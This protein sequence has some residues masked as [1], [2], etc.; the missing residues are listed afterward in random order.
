MVLVIA[1]DGP[2]LP[3]WR[4][5]IRTQGLEG[6]VILLGRWPHAEL[7]SWFQVADAFVLASNYEG[8][9]HVAIE[10]AMQGLPCVLSDAGGNPE[11]TTL[12]PGFTTILPTGDREA[13]IRGLKN[14]SFVR[15]AP[16]IPSARA[17]AE[18]QRLLKGVI[19][20]VKRAS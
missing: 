12:L 19:D 6:R 18:V 20:S 7:A 16:F 4:E 1:G 10:A 5:L 17:A 3:T 2:L 15:K 14:F 8:F 11:A 9:P 13:W